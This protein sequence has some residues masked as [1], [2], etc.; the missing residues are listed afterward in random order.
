MGV[1]TV[2]AISG[3]FCETNLHNGL[4]NDFER[5]SCKER[6]G[7]ALQFEDVKRRLRIF[8]RKSTMA[9]TR[10]DTSTRFKVASKGSFSGRLFRW[11]SWFTEYICRGDWQL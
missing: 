11:E 7:V 10:S 2:A 4:A 5:L 3:L 1:V 9:E 6:R 8:D